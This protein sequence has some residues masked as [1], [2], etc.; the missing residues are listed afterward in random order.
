[1]IGRECRRIGRGR[2]YVGSA[3]AGGGGGG[4]GEMTWIEK[5]EE[6]MG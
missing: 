2:R 6:R 3:S 5:E 1:M 4:G